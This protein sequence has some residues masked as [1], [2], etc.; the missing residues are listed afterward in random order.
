MTDVVERVASP[1][2]VVVFGQIGGGA[3]WM[4][5]CGRMLL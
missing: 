2:A 1:V 5:M 4:L 3:I